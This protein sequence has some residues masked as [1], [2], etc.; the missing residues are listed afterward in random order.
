MFYSTLQFIYKSVDRSSL[1]SLLCTMLFICA[2]VLLPVVCANLPYVKV[3]RNFTTVCQDG[4]IL[5]AWSPKYDLDRETRLLRGTVYLFGLFYVFLGVSIVADKFM[6]AIE[7]IT[8]SQRV[9]FVPKKKGGKDKIV[10]QIWN[11][12]VAN[13]TLMA[14]G[15]SCP[16]I[17][18][19]VIE[20]FAKNFQAGELGPG[21]IVGSAAYNLFG[22]VALCVAVIPKGQVR[23]IKKLAVY[24]VTAF[25]SVFAY[26]WLYYIIA[27][28]SEGEV[29]VW[30]AVLTFMFFPMT[31]ITAYL[32]DKCTAK[33]LAKSDEE[34]KGQEILG[35]TLEQ[36]RSNFSDLLKELRTKNPKRTMKQLEGLAEEII[37]Q[38]GPKSRAYYRR[39][40][41]GN[42]LG[43]SDKS[44]RHADALKPGPVYSAAFGSYFVFDRP[45]Y[46]VLESIGVFEV[47]VKLEGAGLKEYV[48][49]EYYTENG[50]AKEGLD[51]ICASGV[52]VFKPGDVKRGIPIQIIEDAVFEKDEYFYIHLANIKAHS[53]D[54]KFIKLGKPS[55]AEIAII[56]DDHAGIFMFEDEIIDV[57][58][59]EGVYDLP[60]VRCG[61][62]RGEIKIPYWTIPGTAEAAIDFIESSG[63]V[64]FQDE[65]TRLESDGIKNDKVLSNFSTN[66]TQYVNLH[67]IKYCF[68]DKL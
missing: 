26:I 50:T 20:V 13:L 25:W 22:I 27:V 52:L 12:T 8:S 33:G 24:F 21:T 23:K 36:A 47:F 60:V 41:I 17:L 54:N 28:S 37:E 16:E 5:P 38:S 46:T 63:Y 10:T 3:S 11:E 57:T 56:D 42:I 29:E 48:T 35:E 51:Y 65:E 40:V 64:Q 30:E 6:N 14:L 55:S 2:V 34:G 31:V 44:Y 7:K 61:G 53:P 62:T 19:S 15:S 39:M 1:T 45:L 58:E 18:L 59:R 49:M 67:N 9:V 66:F 43:K 4:L 32:T 68:S